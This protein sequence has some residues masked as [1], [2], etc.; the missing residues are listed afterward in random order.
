MYTLFVFQVWC[1]I[2]NIHFGRS[3]INTARFIT[4]AATRV[5]WRH[6]V[7]SDFAQRK[8]GTARF[9]QFRMK[10][11]LSFYELEA[12][13][14]QSPTKLPQVSLIWHFYVQSPGK[15]G[16]SVERLDHLKKCTGQSPISLDLQQNSSCQKKRETLQYMGAGPFHATCSPDIPPTRPEWKLPT[17]FKRPGRKG[18]TK[19][20][21]YLIKKKCKC[22][23]ELVL[24]SGRKGRGYQ[25]LH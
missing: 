3:P 2:S 21:L 16:P 14:Q 9:K 24:H 22:S 4:A 13:C 10:N 23:F 12:F 6:C 11:D 8:K 5:Q 25:K 17:A 15:H 20:A 18:P 1:T 7:R 19:S